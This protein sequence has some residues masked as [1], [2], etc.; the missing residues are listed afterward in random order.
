M[1]KY[2]NYHTKVSTDKEATESTPNRIGRKEA[3]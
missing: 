3:I 2:Y 1:A